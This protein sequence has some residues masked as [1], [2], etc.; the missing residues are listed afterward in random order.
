MSETALVGCVGIVTTPV[1]GGDLP[2]EVRVVVEG[3]PHYYIAYHRE[4]LAVGQQVLV[5]NN[6]GSRQLD[7]E[8]WDQPGLGIADVVGPHEGF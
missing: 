8:P 1:R 5:I 2:G 3:L 4:P 6:R 7:V